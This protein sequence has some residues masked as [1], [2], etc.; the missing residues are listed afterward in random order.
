MNARPTLG[1]SLPEYIRK[2]MSNGP[3]KKNLKPQMASYIRP[4]F[5]ERWLTDH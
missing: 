4:K 5:G 1:V 3:S 2:E